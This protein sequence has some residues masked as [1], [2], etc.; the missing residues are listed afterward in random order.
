MVESM[1]NRVSA[2]LALYLADN[3]T[4]GVTFFF[5]LMLLMSKSEIMSATEIK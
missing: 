4:L 5:C 3:T 1:L 2:H